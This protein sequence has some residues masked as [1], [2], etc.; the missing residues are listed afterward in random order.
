MGVTKVTLR[1]RLLPSGKITLYLDFYPPLRDPHSRKYVRHEYLG[2]YLVNKPRFQSDKDAN[3]EKIAQAEA[4]RSERELAIIRGQYDFLDK[5]KL[6]MDFLAYFKTKLDTKDQKWIRV[7]DHFSNYCGGVCKMGDITVPFCEGFRHTFATLQVNEGT[8]IYTVSHLLT[9]ANV[10]T[11]QIYADI[12]DKSK[13]D[14]VERIKI[15]S[16]K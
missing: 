13:L 8:D 10:G 6:K 12:V 5:T 14:A 2:I 9:H 11:T 4:I 1:K 3:K 15:K 16:D 7:Y